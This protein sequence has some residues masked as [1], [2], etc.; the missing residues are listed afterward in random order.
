V[1]RIVDQA[2]VLIQENS[3]SLLKR[4][5]VLYQIRLSLAPIP[6]KIDIAHSIIL[7]L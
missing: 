4:D 3:L 5:A 7:A 6:G 2:G 1:I